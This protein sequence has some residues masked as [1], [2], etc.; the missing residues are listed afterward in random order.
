[1][2]KKY[3]V[4]SVILFVVV[5]AVVVL[6][7]VYRHQIKQV[8]SGAKVYTQSEYDEAYNKGAA[9]R[10]YYKSQS[11]TFK[12][13]LDDALAALKKESELRQSAENNNQALSADN[14]ALR[15]DIARLEALV[16]K[17]EALMALKVGDNQVLVT[18]Q[19]AGKVVDIAI[20]DKGAKITD[21]YV[22]TFKDGELHEFN[23]WMRDGQRV[24]FDT[25][26][27]S[28]NTVLEANISYKY[29]VKFVDGTDTILTNVVNK[30]SLLTLPEDASKVGFDFLGYYVAGVKIDQ[31]SYRVTGDVTV[32]LKYQIQTYTITFKTKIYHAADGTN[33]I[34]GVDSVY[35]ELAVIDT[36]VITYGDLL[37]LITAPDEPAGTGR[38]FYK[39]MYCKAEYEAQT[40]FTGKEK[41]FKLE[42]INTS[43]FKPTGN[44]TLYAD[45]FEGSGYGEDEGHIPGKDN[46]PEFGN[47]SGR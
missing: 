30:G 19:V 29:T 18:F 31:E 7:Y 26:T 27:F 3:I 8:F 4:L 32:E 2:N 24:D 38:V 44:I 20:V 28:A 41:D 45:Y 10:D 34:D 12:K 43:T 39:W 16:K 1:M 37:T 47:E 15:D 22:V 14:E 13:K 33:I 46:R 25:F 40:N 35:Y 36:R 21:P 9:D 11:D 6:G 17:Y 42:Y 5:A 23:Y